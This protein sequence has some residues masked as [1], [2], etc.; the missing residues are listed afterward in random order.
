M[1]LLSVTEVNDLLCDRTL[2]YSVIG[3]SLVTIFLKANNPVFRIVC[4][5]ISMLIGKV[6]GKE[7][8]KLVLGKLAVN[9]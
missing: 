1:E 3:I 4:I 8:A 6:V 5:F 9:C 7:I 2:I